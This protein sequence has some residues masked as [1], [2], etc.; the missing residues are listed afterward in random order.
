MATPARTLGVSPEL[1][2][3]TVSNQ[4]T[5]APRQPD[6]NQSGA[7]PQDTVTLSA[8]ALAQTTAATQGAEVPEN[9]QIATAADANAPPPAAT[10]NGSGNAPNAAPAQTGNQQA[11]TTTT[12]SS[13]QQELAQLAILLQQLGINPGS[14]STDEQI[15]LLTYMSDPAALANAVKSMDTIGIPPATNPNP[16]QN[17][18][19]AKSSGVQGLNILA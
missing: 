12:A 16:S 13:Q 4:N 19:G 5:S 7:L 3:Q 8:T 1:I 10:A 6:S 18:N 15:Q 14:I 11:A 9:Q 17:V 2:N